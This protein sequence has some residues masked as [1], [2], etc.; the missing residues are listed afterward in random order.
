MVKQE[1]MHLKFRIQETF[2]R[3]DKDKI[4][5]SRWKYFLYFKLKVL[6]LRVT[7]YN[8]FFPFLVYPHYDVFKDF[9]AVCDITSSTLVTRG[10][11][12]V[13]P[14]ILGL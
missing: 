12:H 13:L 8:F 5:K 3:F 14:C 7:Y 10:V 2:E 9:D 1:L 11:I 6:N 4:C